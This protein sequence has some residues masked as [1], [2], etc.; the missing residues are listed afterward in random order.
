MMSKED[1]TKMEFFFS[2][3]VIDFLNH[4]AHFLEYKTLQSKA[5]G[6]K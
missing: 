1:Y 6:Y 2:M 4:V 3:T 5:N